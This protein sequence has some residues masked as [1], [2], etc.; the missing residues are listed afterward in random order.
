MSYTVPAGLYALGCPT[1]EDPVV[2]TANYKVSYDIV[3]RELSG[4]NVWLLVLETNGIN[5]WCAAGKGTFGTAE[6]VKRIEATALA[7]VVKHRVL[8]L[9][10]LGASGVAAHMVEKLTGFRVRYATVRASDLPE[11]L[12]CGMKTRP[13]MRE[14]TF[15]ARERLALTPIEVFAGFR[16]SFPFLVLLFLAGAFSAHAFSPWSGLYPVLACS[17]AILAGAFAA[18]VL[19]PWLPS[20]YFSVK[21][22]ITGLLWALI[23]YLFRGG[24]WNMQLT[25]SS[26]LLLP[27]ISSFLA[28]NFTGSTPFTS[29]SGVRKEMRQSLPFLAAAVLLGIIFFVAGLLAG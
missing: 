28:L 26:F 18:P 11:F 25:L 3:R 5:V 2:V 24:G 14:L 4:R 7:S 22:A 20:R 12:D 17:G 1:A 9:P 6:L 27:A 16:K 10:I 29:P 13:A 21:G 23:L 8:V 19:L 15:T